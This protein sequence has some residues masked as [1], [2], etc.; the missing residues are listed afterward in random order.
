VESDLSFGDLVCS[1][2]SSVF[3]SFLLLLE[4]FLIIGEF[5]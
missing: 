4:F 2:D 5:F 1:Y 3:G